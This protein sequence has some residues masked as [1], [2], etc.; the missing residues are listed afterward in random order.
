MSERGN[1]SQMDYL[2]LKRMHDR[3]KS[4]QR[5][6]NLANK[7]PQPAA[8]ETEEIQIPAAQ[9][10][11]AAARVEEAPRRGAQA[12]SMVQAEPEP[13]EELELGGDQ[14][15]GEEIYDTGEPDEVP[16]ER[17]TGLFNDSQ[18]PFNQFFVAFG[19][20]KDKMAERKAKKAALE[21]EPGAADEIPAEEG[22]PVD[23]ELEDLGEGAFED[24]NQ[25]GMLGKLTGAFK[26]FS[27][28][29]KKDGDLDLD[30]LTDEELDALSDEE[31][32]ELYFDDEDADGEE[33]TEE[34]PAGDAA[35]EEIPAAPAAAEPAEDFAVAE[36]P[37]A[38][39]E[40][41][42]EDLDDEEYDDLDDEDYDL[43]DEDY[44]LEEE[45][46][47]PRKKRGLKGVLSLFMRKE[48]KEPEPEEDEVED[49]FSFDFDVFGE[50]FQPVLSE[51]Q[52]AVP[53]GEETVEENN[54][55]TVPAEETS[56]AQDAEVMVASGMTRRER[57]ELAMKKAAD[58]AAR[59]EAAL[60]EA[61]AEAQEE[62]PEAVEEPAPE[63]PAEPEPV[64]EEQP[65][66]EE[67]VREVTPSI[68][69]DP[70]TDDMMIAEVDEPTREFKPLHAPAPAETFDF[71]DDEDEE[72]EAEEEEEKPEKKGLFGRRKAK[73]AVEEDEDE[74]EEA[75]EEKP[76]KKSRRSRKAEEEDEEE[77]EAPR[78][79]RRSR[80]ED[81]DEDD[82][83]EEYESRRSRR[84]R[85]RRIREEEDDEYEEY[86]S[87]HSRRSRYEDED[88]DDDIDY[89]NYDYNDDD[90]AGHG[91]LYHL[92]GFLKAVT[93]FVI[94]LLVIV[95]G[96]NVWE[97]IG[98]RN[99]SDSPVDSLS[100]HLRDYAP[101]VFD[102]LFP[103]AGESV[104]EAADDGAIE[105]G[106]GWDTTGDEGEAADTESEPE[107]VG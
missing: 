4:K 13:V 94:V 55:K 103:V 36:E 44:D 69:D 66:A 24:E 51:E 68:F 91:F 57:R 17:G 40:S 21:E 28:G 60:A 90:G 25:G 41:D 87:R 65:A 8:E 85:R 93:V 104:A 10:P 14:D 96:L 39:Y 99:G 75:E 9:E 56:A 84:E 61:E 48:E 38:E 107:L 101:G 97:F 78:R 70:V 86:E 3:Y 33:L 2:E 63:V 53:K 45:E 15:A 95:I 29:K 43:A 12:D 59:L 62:V 30:D 82:E 106:D 89:D 23:P 20:M 58:E 72:E 80:Y 6:A 52:P 64:V 50:Q 47:A 105:L 11:V 88:E 34:L 26:K 71:F 77:E 76:A 74:E 22:E 7:K 37:A 79:S 19:K 49:D 31:L 100:E 32:D 16:A 73:K 42:G 98:N 81:E 27:F 1:G 54:V 18:N 83:E 46:E 35:E 5:M 67:P 102:V 92:S